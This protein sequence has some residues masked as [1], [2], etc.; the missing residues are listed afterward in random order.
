MDSFSLICRFCV[1]FSQQA[2]AFVLPVVIGIHQIHGIASRKA[3]Q[4]PKAHG[5]RYLQKQEQ[6]GV[7]EDHRHTNPKDVGVV[8]PVAQWKDAQKQK[9]HQPQATATGKFIGSI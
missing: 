2:A 9:V 8:A 4:G 7:A 3:D 1:H 5:L 6:E